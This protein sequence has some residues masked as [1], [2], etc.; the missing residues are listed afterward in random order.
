MS[1]SSATYHLVHREVQQTGAR[2]V[3]VSKTRPVA[4]IR[5]LYELG[6]RDFG[7]NRV[8]ELLEKQA[9]LPNDIN[10]HFIGHLQRN[11]VKYI[12]PFVHLI[13]AVDTPQ[14]LRE[15]DK[16]G[17]KHQRQ[18]PALLQFHIAEESSKYGLDPA[19]ADS[20]FTDLDPSELDGVKICGVMGMAT[21]TDHDEQIS[22][23]F[24]L[25]ADTFRHLQ[26]TRFSEVDHFR[27][28]SMGMSGDYPIA[29]Q[30][31]STLVR[32]GSLLFAP[33]V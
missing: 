18:I 22:T 9:V 23:E 30:H 4:Q 20:I 3:A 14:L 6:H 2:L 31:G 27:E 29:L 16:Q 11:K 7:E 24:T 32:V 1:I 28:I 8:P 19:V 33:R 5:A 15:I 21:N 26:Q 13:H 25:L 17:R 10:W 12:A